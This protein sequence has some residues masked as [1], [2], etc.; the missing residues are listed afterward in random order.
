[1]PT[2]STLGVPTIPTA[3][4]R[5]RKARDLR[6][7]ELAELL[8][9]TQPT[10]VNY[11]LGYSRPRRDVLRKLET[12]FNAPASDLLAKDDTEYIPVIQAYYPGTCKLC[13]GYFG[14]WAQISQTPEGWAHALCALD[15]LSGPDMERGDAVAGAAPQSS[16]AA[17]AQSDEV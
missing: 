12:I 1:M 2:T 4:R 6:Q 8:G 11:E 13:G 3:L 10:V 16:H 7:A 17:T 14:R 15:A 9:V 5:A